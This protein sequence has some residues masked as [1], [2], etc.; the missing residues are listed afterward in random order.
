LD[1]TGERHVVTLTNAGLDD[2]SSNVIVPMRFA[3]GAANRQ[4][5]FSAAER[6]LRATVSNRSLPC[7]P[8]ANLHPAVSN[9]SLPISAQIQRTFLL[10]HFRNTGVIQEPAACELLN[11]NSRVRLYLDPRLKETH[12]V[13]QLRSQCEWL[14]SAAESQ[15]LPITE[16][17]IGKIS[18][19]DYDDKLTFVITNLDERTIP[20]NDVAPVHGCI[21]NIDFQSYSALGG[22]IVYL[23]VAILN[24]PQQEQASLLTHELAHAAV[25]SIPLERE[26]DMSNHPLAARSVSVF[27]ERGRDSNTDIPGVAAAGADTSRVA[28][29]HKIPSWLNEAVAHLMELRCLGTADSSASTSGNFQRRI[30]HFLANTACSP[31]VAAEHVMSP[32]E[33]RGGSRGAATLFLKPWLTSPESLQRFIET[34]ASLDHR[35]EVLADNSFAEIFRD[36]TLSMAEVS[37]KHQPLHA[38]FVPAGNE[39]EQFSLLGTA[40]KCFECPEDFSMIVI[41]SDVA[42]KLQISIIEPDTRVTLVRSISKYGEALPKDRNND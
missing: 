22:D 5:G 36:W 23:D 32:D 41:E 15:A 24:L 40:F 2:K 3:S 31:I 20:S 34:D 39:Q 35:M 26:P 42:A 27:F 33:R 11:D 12:H 14:I 25:C 37:V 4:W 6:S 16:T 18:D 38:D 28:V 21:R 29:P 13:E 1:V 19:V 8:D 9:E 30:E 7:E 10:P 17:W